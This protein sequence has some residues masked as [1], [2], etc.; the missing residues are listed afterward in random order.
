MGASAKDNRIDVY[1]YG[2][3]IGAKT[4]KGTKGDDLIN[5]MG[6]SITQNGGTYYMDGGLG[7]D[8][9]VIP[10]TSQLLRSFKSFGKK[11]Q[12]EIEYMEFDATSVEYLV[13]DDITLEVTSK[14][15]VSSSWR[16]KGLSVKTEPEDSTLSGQS[17]T[18]EKAVNQYGV[19]VITFLASDGSR[20]LADGNNFVFDGNK[21]LSWQNSSSEPIIG[22]VWSALY[23]PSFF[24]HNELKSDVGSWAIMQDSAKGYISWSDGTIAAW[25]DVTGY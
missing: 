13:F 8:S 21:D 1:S 6:F 9:L 5:P 4:K 25:L 2:S 17:G 10:A 19:D 7:R 3:I 23:S 16:P 18:W 11:A 15:L 12:F 20:F 22:K 24:S 14:G